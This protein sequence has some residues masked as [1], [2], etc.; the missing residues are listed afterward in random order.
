MKAILAWI[1]APWAGL[2][3]TMHYL[4][5]RALGLKAKIVLRPERALAYTQ[6][7]T[8]HAWQELA[9]GLAP[10]AFAVPVLWIGWGNFE[11]TA[12]V[13]AWWIGCAHDFVQVVGLTA[14]SSS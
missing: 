9:I 8:E 13:V 3:E 7:L 6:V 5:A 1:G 10:A 14:R 12:L 11:V 2:H 4:A